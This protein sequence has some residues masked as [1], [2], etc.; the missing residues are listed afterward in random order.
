MLE[1]QGGRVW[2]QYREGEGRD[3]WRDRWWGSC[4]WADRAMHGCQREQGPVVKCG[5]QIVD[6]P[7]RKRWW[8]ARGNGCARA[9]E[10]C[11]FL[12]P[13]PEPPDQNLCFDKCWVVCVCT[14]MRQ[15]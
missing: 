3:R 12:G 11:R 6:P 7:C 10:Q 15:A 5:R 13:S 1:E 14:E 9:C 2:L 4:G 8:Q